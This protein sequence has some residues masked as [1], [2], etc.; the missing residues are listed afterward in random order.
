MQR[1]NRLQSANEVQPTYVFNRRTS[2][3]EAGNKYY[4]RIAT[5][6]W[7]GAIQ[8]NPT[9]PDCNVLSNCVG[10]AN[11]RFN[12]IGGYNSCKYQLTSNAANFMS[13]AASYGLRTGSKPKLGA[14]MVWA[15][16]KSGAGHVAI[17][18]HVDSDTQVQTT[19]SAYYGSAFYKLTRSKGSG[20]W[21]S[22]S[23]YS[24]IGFIYNP[25]VPDTENIDEKIYDGGPVQDT[26]SD[27]IYR[28]YSNSSQ[29]RNYNSSLINFQETR[30]FI[31]RVSDRDVD[32][33]DHGT[34]LLSYP[35]LVE[36]PYINVTIG[37][38]TFGKYNETRT[39]SAIIINY[40]NFIT[41]LE[42]TKVNGQVN[43]YTINMLYQIR[44]GDDPNFID[45]ILSSVGYGVIKISYG[46]YASPSF[47]YKEEQAIITKVTSRVNFSTS[48]IQYT[49]SC[50]STAMQLLAGNYPFLYHAKAK[51]SDIIYNML[52]QASFYKLD[53][54]FP[55]LTGKNLDKNFS[56]FI[57]TDDQ[58]VEIPA[59]NY[60][61]P[62]SYINFLVTYMIPESDNA[63]ST[64]R[65][66][67]YYLTIHDDSY[68]D[69]SDVGGTYFK[70]TKIPTSYRTVPTYNTYTVD[71]G[72]P[73]GDNPGENLVMDFSLTDDNSWSLLYDYSQSDMGAS[74]QNYSYS[75][76]DYGQAVQHYSPNVTINSVKGKTTAAMQ[77]WWTRMTEFPISATLIIKGLVRSAMLMS[78][79]RVNSFFY[80][81]K[82]VSSGLYIV[83]KQQ[84]KVDGSGYRTVLSLT[85]IAGADEYIIRK[86]YTR[87]VEVAERPRQPAVSYSQDTNEDYQTQEEII[88][89]IQEDNNTHGTSAYSGVLQ[90]L[91]G[92]YI[93]HYS[94]QLYVLCNL[95]THEIYTDPNK[96]PF[97][98]DDTHSSS[99]TDLE[100]DNTAIAFRKV[101]SLFGDPEYFT[102]E[103]YNAF[104]SESTALQFGYYSRLPQN[105]DGIAVRYVNG[106]GTTS[107]EVM[108]SV[109]GQVYFVPNDGV[110]RTE[111]SPPPDS[112]DPP[113]YSL[114]HASR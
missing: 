86:N 94:A 2:K 69:Y 113:G 4:I 14:I 34:S 13:S 5:G 82:H 24:F 108:I 114:S 91:G 87:Q 41:G 58:A 46:D 99:D 16:G 98:S 18:E 10:Y 110:W 100:Y 33:P 93:V 44:L 7:N 31:G 39:Q 109:N 27:D 70:I 67:T 36:A 72:Y 28:S 104:D 81:K 19:E 26:S 32:S 47:I 25:A 35:S 22:G 95:Q 66:A 11:G 73:G 84:D 21:G 107:D 61:D 59:K 90:I 9:D 85:R 62:L 37:G 60:M 68:A 12:E 40:P 89:I 29:Y 79:I 20:N 106:L 74:M 15:G 64:Q 3:P 45:K 63:A 42:V 103:E 75:I 48:S 96:W 102:Q 65:S 76:N 54:I 71:V 112:L 38:Y 57:A 83:T 97:V 101:E 111:I 105:C 30:D 17:V 50:T 8:G 52:Q 6:G 23:Q 92:E 55:A 49:I 80:G 1:E 43:M 77:S 51:P 56:K 53:T 78:Y 88:N